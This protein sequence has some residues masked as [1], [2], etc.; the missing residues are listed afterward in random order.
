MIIARITAIGFTDQAESHTPTD[1][2]IN[3]RKISSSIMPHSNQAVRMPAINFSLD[4]CKTLKVSKVGGFR[5]TLDARQSA[6]GEQATIKTIQAK[7]AQIGKG[8]EFGLASLSLFRSS[9][10]SSNMKTSYLYIFPCKV[11]RMERQTNPYSL[12]QQ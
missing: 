6:I 12:G 9:I 5:I 4:C 7:A 3:P 2:N 8:H 11:S 1:F 10:T